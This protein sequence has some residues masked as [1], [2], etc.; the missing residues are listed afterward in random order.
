MLEA[1]PFTRLPIVDQK[2]LRLWQKHRFFAEFAKITSNIKSH[3]L[4]R[5]KIRRKPVF[6][7]WKENGIFSWE[8]AKWLGEVQVV[9]QL[10][11]KGKNLP[12]LCK[13]D[14]FDKRFGLSW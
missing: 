8:I 5:L 3:E 14:V 9:V 2:S 6:F 12:S 13:K 10:H 1:I 11:G 7:I 4:R